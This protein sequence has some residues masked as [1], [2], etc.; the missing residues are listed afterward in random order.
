[1]CDVYQTSC[2]PAKLAIDDNDLTDEAGEETLI[3][4]EQI[5]REREKLAVMMRA[6]ASELINELHC[7][8]SKQH[9]HHFPC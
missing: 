5:E 7:L 1:M 2:W 4:A 9:A 3:H 6:G 8:T